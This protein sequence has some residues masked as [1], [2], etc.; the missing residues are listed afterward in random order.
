M[1]RFT[2][3]HPSSSASTR[4]QETWL[5]AAFSAQ[6]PA[7]VRPPFVSFLSFVVPR[8]QRFNPS[9]HA[10]HN[11]PHALSGPLR[12]SPAL[13]FFAP[14]L[15]PQAPPAPG[16]GDLAVARL[17][18]D[19]ERFDWHRAS[20]EAQKQ[21]EFREWA[22]RPEVREELFPEH[23]G[24]GRRAGRLAP[25]LAQRPARRPGAAGAA[26]LPGRDQPRG[27]RPPRARIFWPDP[28]AAGGSRSRRRW[29]K[30]GQTWSNQN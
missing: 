17:Q 9:T 6:G 10:L 13:S 27:A 1:S 4:V 21:K 29:V 11:P 25:R 24:A 19:R 28:G 20:T 3:L 12:P 22:Q 5:A 26:L 15:L 16:R 8:L 18:L 30:P 14:P 7:C 2:R 23:S